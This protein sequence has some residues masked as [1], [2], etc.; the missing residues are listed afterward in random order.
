M[1]ISQKKNRWRKVINI[2]Y[3]NCFIHREKPLSV[4]IFSQNKGTIS[5]ISENTSSGALVINET[6]LHVAGTFCSI[7]TIIVKIF[8]LYILCAFEY[9]RFF[10]TASI[11]HF[12]LN[13]FYTEYCDFVV[14]L[15][16]HMLDMYSSHKTFIFLLFSFTVYAVLYILYILY[17]N[18]VNELI[19]WLN[20]KW[21]NWMAKEIYKWLER[22]WYD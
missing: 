11:N 8:L 9:F 3:T 6:I 4:Y 5:L 19:K 7:I 18:N 2:I 10:L 20:D 12:F 1:C 13:T 21:I 22:L 15:P 17:I 14:R 16:Q